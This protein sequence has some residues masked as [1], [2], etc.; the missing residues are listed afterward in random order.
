LIK[1]LET[2]CIDDEIIK[3]IHYINIDESDRGVI[4]GIIYNFQDLKNQLSHTP[5]CIWVHE[6]KLCQ[7]SMREKLQKIGVSYTKVLC[8]QSYNASLVSAGE[9]IKMMKKYPFLMI[10]GEIVKSPF[11]KKK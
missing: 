6:E 7:Y 4:E 5:I 8:V 9:H 11:Y 2:V 10:D 1:K 3:Y